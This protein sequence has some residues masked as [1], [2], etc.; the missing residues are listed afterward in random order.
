MKDI[1][2][3][4]VFVPA[5]LKSEARDLISDALVKLRQ[6]H[7]DQMGDIWMDS[8]EEFEEEDDD[9]GDSEAN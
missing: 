8:W 5:E 3:A 4:S 1:A 6:A 2:F 9:E 7:P